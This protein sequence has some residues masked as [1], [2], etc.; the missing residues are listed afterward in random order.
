MQMCIVLTMFTLRVQAKSCKMRVGSMYN[1]V[2]DQLNPSC[3]KFVQTRQLVLH[4]IDQ[5]SVGVFLSFEAYSV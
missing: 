4:E 5:F 1:F 3:Q 2:L